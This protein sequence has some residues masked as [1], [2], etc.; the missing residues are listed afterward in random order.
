MQFELEMEKTKVLIAD[1]HALT[2][3][4]VKSILSKRKNIHLAGEAKDSRELSEKIKKLQPDIVIIDFDIPGYFSMDDIAFIRKNY[5]Q[6]SI[7]VIST[8]QKKE[9][10]LK[11]LEY[12]VKVYLLK[13]CDEEEVVNAV[14]SSAKKENFFCGKVMDAI[15]EKVTHHCP[16]GS[17]CHHCQG[18]SLSEREVEIIKLITECHT[19]SEIAKRLFLSF[20]TISTHRKNI[21]KKLHIHNS[22]ELIFFALKKGIIKPQEN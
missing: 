4:G 16:A 17:G 14:C 20:H 5:P 9:D 10:I 21:F 3:E 6:I 13:E 12:G 15:L 22:S 19:T 1:T 7:L 8:N 18:V 11:V 2:R